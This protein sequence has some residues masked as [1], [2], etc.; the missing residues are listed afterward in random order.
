MRNGNVVRIDGGCITDF[1]TFHDTFAKAFA[2]PEWYGRNWDAWIDLMT[3]FDEPE[4]MCGFSVSPGE[5]VTVLIENAEAFRHQ[6]PETYNTF[7]D[8]SA[9]VNWRRLKVGE[10]AYLCIAF[11]H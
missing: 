3:H 11:S 4:P 10:A 6:T 1:E 2:F 5:S 8:C 7:I 9:F